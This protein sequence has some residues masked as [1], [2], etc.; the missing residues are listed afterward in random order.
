MADYKVFNPKLDWHMPTDEI[1]HDDM[2]RIE[3]GI[4]EASARISI[5]KTD[6]DGTTALMDDGTYKKIVT[7]EVLDDLVGDILGGAF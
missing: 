6:G 4:G 2:N 3:R 7:M 1:T 5:L